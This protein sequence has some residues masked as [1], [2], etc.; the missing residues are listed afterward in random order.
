MQIDSVFVT[1]SGRR[2]SYFFVLVLGFFYAIFL[3]YI[4]GMDGFFD[5]DNYHLFIGWAALNFSSYDYGAVA[6]FHTYL[7]PLIDMVN[8]KAF[9]VHPYVGAT[10]HAVVFS[11]VILFC[12]LLASFSFVA[13]KYKLSTVAA[14]AIGATGAMSVSLFGTFTNEHV[15]ALFV[16]VALFLVV[17]NIE[18]GGGRFFFAAGIFIGFAAGLKLT[19]FSYVIGLLVT[20]FVCSKFNIKLI[21]FACLGSG[22]GF[23]LA[24]GLFMILRFESVGNP[25]FPMANNIFRSPYYPSAWKSY[26][27][28]ELENI[29]YYLSLPFVWLTAADFSEAKQLRDGR[30]LLAYIGIALIVAASLRKRFLTKKQFTIVFF[31]LVS[32]FSWILIFRIYRYL[33]VLELLSGVIFL[34]GVSVFFGQKF[35][36]PKLLS[37]MAASWFLYCVTVYPNWGRRVWQDEFCKS[38]LIDV[39]GGDSVDVVFYADAGLS[40]LSPQLK[41]S[42]IRFASLPSQPWYESRRDVI[43]IDPKGVEISDKSKVYFLQ[44]SKVDPRSKSNY[45]NRLFGGDIYSCK[46]VHTNMQLNPYLCSFKKL[47]DIKLSTVFVGESYRYDTDKILLSSGWSRKEEGH[48]WTEGYRSSVLFK[49][50]S[51]PEGCN[52]FVKI[53]GVALGGQLLSAYINGVEANKE[54]LS[55]KF[56][57]VINIGRIIA[58]DKNTIRLD[59]DLPNATAANSSDPRVLAIALSSL[60]FGCSR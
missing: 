17:K 47:S 38:D 25:I 20:I 57:S 50:D 42:D 7:N 52:P 33:V 53:S 37:I 51:I 54:K 49:I 13:D 6:Q 40:Y 1:R 46:E 59:L 18:V 48:V 8:Y 45:L 14:V 35:F 43:P 39:I 31:F 58:S 19:A 29:T 9:M 5:T 56:E 27:S 15:T 21:F 41:S 28:F 3:H 12:Y 36:S 34:I 2:L 16:L 44:F 24:D 26:G 11:L 60:S 22:F 4:L 10:F 23:L 55:G 30:F 32:W